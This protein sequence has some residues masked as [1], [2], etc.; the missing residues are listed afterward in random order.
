MEVSINT[1][2][3]EAHDDELAKMEADIA[4]ANGGAPE[5]ETPTVETPAEEGTP[6][7]ESAPGEENQPPVEKPATPAPKP[8]GKE[9]EDDDYLSD[10]EVQKLSG[11]AQKRFGRLSSENIRLQKENEFLRKHT[12]KADEPVPEPSTPPINRLPWESTDG[13]EPEGEDPAVVARREALL[14]VAE[15]RRQQ[16]ILDNLQ[17]DSKELETA[18]P[19]FDPKSESYDPTL[20]TKIS[21]WYK[22][23]F[24]DNNDLRLKDFVTELMALREQGIAQGKSE[25]TEKV[26]RQAADQAVTPTAPSGPS[27]D[28]VVKKIQ[29]ARSIAELDKL[30]AQI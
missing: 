11:K 1:A 6:A 29:G 22:G 9:G 2:A 14:A 12:K 19:E 8:T 24:K 25:V 13:D 7:P 10:E 18:Y 3:K 27:S 20:V 15:E 16:A 23:L 21:V 30:E 17:N 5:G 4:K 26:V 28:S